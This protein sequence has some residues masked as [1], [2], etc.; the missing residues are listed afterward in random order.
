MG[1]AGNS[2]D[3][4]G[5]T[6]SFAAP[7]RNL[8]QVLKRAQAVLKEHRYGEALEGLSQ[9]L[10]ASEDYFYQP[11]PKV[12]IYRGLKAE[13]RQLLGEMPREGLDLYEV[14]SG[15]E[16]R[17]KLDRAVATGDAVALAEISGER[18]HTQ[19]GYEATYLL[20]LSYLD[21]GTPLAGGVTLKRL[22]DAGAAAEP[23]EPGLSLTQAACYYQAGMRGLLP[24]G[25]RR[26][27]TPFGANTAGTR[28]PPGRLVPA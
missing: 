24:A 14:R 11:D 20:A 4:N 6:G 8:L 22:R 12:S 19:A 10:S 27:E 3:E 16:A 28:G 15:G 2:A 7:D 5:G 18:F 1:N 26:P 13:A 25:P 17:R 23:F 9:V 21:H